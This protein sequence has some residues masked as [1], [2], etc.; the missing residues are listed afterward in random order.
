MG[1]WYRP[2]QQDFHQSL[3]KSPVMTRFIADLAYCG[4]VGSETIR[5]DHLRM[6]VSFH[7]IPQKP[8]RSL[9]I[10]LLSNE[11]FEDLALVVD[12]HA[13]VAGFA[14]DP[15]ENRVEVPRPLR[16]APHRR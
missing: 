7:P 16:Q 2:R 10:S 14:I 9:A 8:L 11:Y 3:S 6:A 15:H 4:P 13:N 1:G 12:S 5:H